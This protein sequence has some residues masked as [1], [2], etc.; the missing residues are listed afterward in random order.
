MR[1]SGLARV[2]EI[3]KYGLAGHLQWVNRRFDDFA[4]AP[5]KKIGSALQLGKPEPSDFSRAIRN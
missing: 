5:A 2:I 1:F 3:R 4:E